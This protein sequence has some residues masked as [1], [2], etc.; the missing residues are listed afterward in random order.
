L[1]FSEST[2]AL[3]PR[4]TDRLGEDLHLA[5]LLSQE[6]SAVEM[7][8]V[9]ARVTVAQHLRLGTVTERIVRWMQVLRAHRPV[10][11]VWVPLLFCCTPLLVVTTAL[12]KQWAGLFLLLLSRTA[13][14]AKLGARR[15]ELV[16]WFAGELLLLWAFTVACFRR[17][18][19]WRGRSYQVLEGGTIEPLAGG[20]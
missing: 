16:D 8:S 19:V 11:F 18:V 17:R 6:N 3:L 1:G 2:L 5:M 20:T 15:W 13:L 12:E 10:L 14:A 9:P 7:V 4:L